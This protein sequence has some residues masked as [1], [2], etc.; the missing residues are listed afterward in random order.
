MA[1]SCE[2]SAFGPK[3]T[4][5]EVMYDRRVSICSNRRRNRDRPPSSRRLLLELESDLPAGG[6]ISLSMVA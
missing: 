2:M 1:I 5:G 3:R 4:C 6:P